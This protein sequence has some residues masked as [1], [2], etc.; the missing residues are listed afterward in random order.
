MFYK[1]NPTIKNFP[2]TKFIGKNL[3]F[4]YANYRAFELWSSFMPRRKEIQNAIGSE[5][6]NI[7]VNPE[8]FDFHPTTLF[9]KWA[10]ME[11]SSFDVIPDEMEALEIESGLYA[12]FQ[13]KGD[14]Q[15]AAAFFNSIYTK[16]LPNSDYELENRPQFEILGEKYK[17]NDPNSEEEIWIPI[18]LKV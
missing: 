9:V 13:Y 11:V 2:K 3:T 10:A 8:N 17:N 7:Q 18:K 15:G 16:W 5:L 1:M 12:V 6:Y 4:S 14:Q